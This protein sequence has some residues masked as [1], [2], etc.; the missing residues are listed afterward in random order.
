MEIYYVSRI[1]AYR[2]ISKIDAAIFAAVQQQQQ[3][4]QQEQRRRQRQNQLTQI[5]QVMAISNFI[6]SQ[7]AA[8][9]ASSPATVEPATVLG[10]FVFSRPR[11]SRYISN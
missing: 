8:S 3:Q 10:Y 5:V 1:N 6:N 11:S 9:S 7:N 4:Q 2:S